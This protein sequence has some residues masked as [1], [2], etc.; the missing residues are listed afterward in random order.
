MH[1]VKLYFR[2]VNQECDVTFPI[3]CIVRL[4]GAESNYEGAGSNCHVT[5]WI[6]YSVNLKGCNRFF[7]NLKRRRKQFPCLQCLCY[8]IVKNVHTC[9]FIEVGL[10][11]LHRTSLVHLVFF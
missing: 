1:N 4:K 11:E 9:A 7:L 6:R 10:G 5:F 8:V 2:K 3:R